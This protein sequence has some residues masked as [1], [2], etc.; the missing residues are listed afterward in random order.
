MAKYK[1][2]NYNDK[3]TGSPVVICISSYAGKPVKGRAKCSPNDNFDVDK[4]KALAQ[5]RCDL[6]IAQKREKRALRKATEAYQLSIEASFELDDM[7][8]YY[9]DAMAASKKAKEHL[10]NLLKDI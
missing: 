1:F 6:M 5:A 9:A 4:G 3:N 8:T 2:Y 7:K 10:D